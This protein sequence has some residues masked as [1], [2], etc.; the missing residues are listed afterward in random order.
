MVKTGIEGGVVLDIAAVLGAAGD[1]D[2]TDDG[3]PRELARDRAN[4]SQGSET[5]PSP[6]PWAGQCRSTPQSSVSPGIPSPSRRLARNPNSRDFPTSPLPD[7][8]ASSISR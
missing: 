2:D 3:G 8:S 1:S 5:T 7:R 4:R 6:R